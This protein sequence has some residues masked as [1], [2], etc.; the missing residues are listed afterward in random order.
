ML[1]VLVVVAGWFGVTGLLAYRHLQQAE[2]GIGQ[3]RAA[4][5][6][7][8]LGAA[9]TPV[10]RAAD[11][12]A[13]ARSL[14][15]SPVWD[16]AD[17]LPLLRDLTRPVRATT[18]AVDALVGEVAPPLVDVV[19]SLVPRL[20]Q[21]AGRIDVDA[22]AAA[23]APLER[24]ADQVAE[25]RR[26]LAAAPADN[27]PGVVA[28]GQ[29]RLTEQL[30]GLSR[31]LRTG[32]TVVRIGPDMLGA[33]G[34]RRYFV[35]V[36]NLAETRATG[37][38]LAAFLI[39]EADRGDIRIVQSGSNGPLPRSDFATPPLTAEQRRLYA[40]S[41]GFRPWSNANRSPH[42]PWA[43][44]NWSGYWERG[45]GQQIDG[46]VAIDAVTL[47]HALTA[48]GPVTLRDGLVLSADNVV[49]T[50]LSDLYR[51]FPTARDRDERQSYLQHAADV[52]ATAMLEGAGLDRAFL[53]E[54]YLA[55]RGGHVALWSRHEAEQEVIEARPF[56]G[57]SLAEAEGNA[58]GVTTNNAAGGKL[59][60]YLRRRMRY[61]VTACDAA[62]ST[63]EIT[64]SLANTAPAEGLPPY[65][66]L[67]EDDPDPDAP[68]SQNKVEVL[69]YA[70]GGARLESAAGRLEQA[71]ELGLTRWSGVVEI[72]PGQT[73]ELTLRA[74][75]PRSDERPSVLVV[76]SVAP[77]EVDADGWRCPGQPPS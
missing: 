15:H 58:V 46:V 65:V 7:D 14:T 56:L 21:A 20:Q 68:R 27:A 41:R 2:A 11:H 34:P 30:D 9:R 47:Q 40:D 59:D 25:I 6:G 64:V 43:A 54:M 1:A 62:T 8:D 55:T 69:I 28:D 38:L 26:T 45:T 29:R 16:A 66:V 49:Q 61:T 67:R 13:A 4:L 35:G 18:V 70:P 71:F 77:V 75:L 12:A 19:T 74:V 53:Y 76:P 52:V 10:A 22:I 39:V 48:V 32:L 33:E 63:A 51:R 44:A 72:D 60:Y 50:L 17:R 31:V 5:D 23:E 36:Q 42:F 3:A 24:A 37:G 57:H 73:V